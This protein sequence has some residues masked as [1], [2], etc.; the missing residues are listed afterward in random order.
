MRFL[1]L[2]R[3]IHM[4]NKNPSNIFLIT[5]LYAVVLL[6]D[7]PVRTRYIMVDQFGYRP[8]D[9]KVAV[10]AD[11]Q[12][13]RNAADSFVPGSFL[14]VRRSETD[15]I[16][17]S[18]IPA[19]WNNGQTHSQSGDRGW[20]FDFTAVETEGI[21]FIYDPANQV[22]SYPFEINETVYLDLLKTAFKMYFYNR[23]GMAK[24]E[25]FADPC[26]TDGPAFCG[27]HQ[28]TEA[29]YVEDKNNESLIR[30]MSGGWF[31]A[32]DYNKYVTNAE[33][34]LHQLLDAYSQN[35][36]VWT[37]DFNIPESYNGLPD[38]ID[39]IIWELDWIK[40]M[41]GMVDGGV[42]IKMGSLV[43]TSGSPPSTDKASRY[44]G[45][46]CS[47]STLTAASVFAHSALIFSEF[48]QLDDYVDDLIQRAILAWQWVGKHDI[49]ENCDSQEI[50][51]GDAD[52][53]RRD[54]AMMAVTAAV[55]LFAVTGDDLYND[56]VIDHYREVEAMEW[57]GPYRSA[58]GDALLYYASRMDGDQTVQ[59]DILDSKISQAKSDKLYRFYDNL[60]LYRAY[61]PDP[62]YH[63]GSNVVKLDVGNV[64]YDMIVYE[65]DPAGYDQYLEKA[66]SS[67]H[68]LHGVNP[69]SKV[70]LS[71]VYE[72]GADNCVNEIYHKWYVSKTKWDNALISECGPAP[73]YVIGG[74]NKKYS[75][76]EP[77]IKNQ[78]VQKAYKD[79]NDYSNAWEITEA[80]IYYQS[81]YL[82]LLSKFVGKISE[83]PPVNHPPVAVNDTLSVPQDAEI[84]IQVLANDSDADGDLLVIQSVDTA[85]IS[86]SVRIDEGD[87]AITYNSAP[88]YAGE[89]SLKY[90]ISDGQGGMDTASVHITVIA[91]NHPPVAMIDSLTVQQDS[92]VTVHVLENDSDPDGDPL[93]ILEA[94]DAGTSGSVAVDPGDTTLTFTP[95]PGFSGE[96][97]FEYVISD[98]QGGLDTAEVRITVEEGM[99]VGGIAPVPDVFALFQNHPNPFNPKTQILISLCR[100][101]PVIIE[102]TDILGKTVTTLA[103]Y[104]LLGAG[105]HTFSFDGSG[106]SAG[107]YFCRLQSGP[108]IQVKKLVLIK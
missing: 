106:L 53:S 5:I 24:E 1:I 36:D 57:W 61:M 58:S 67:L 2:I 49:R 12:K 38:L 102:I 35:P 92:V 64:N 96:T 82:K 81:A 76:S 85:G 107:I 62:Q 101:G 95:A 28:D 89:D 87:T 37:D 13:G 77:G 84:L 59:N 40:K 29:R 70:Y 45:P 99:G 65:L 41:Q 54:Q 105:I 8:M 18:G 72:I 47:S 46:K 48:S 44:Y 26:W 100:P 93:D 4:P 90:L 69:W 27:P 104:E 21:Y 30:D 97:V 33:E 20:W 94:G 7:P 31:D 23:C 6:A 42:H 74:P 79:D 16:V 51:S 55:Y 68:Y 52:I 80:G 32:G 63:W 86:G 73:G 10:I 50:K 91:M 22:G 34:V 3:E 43:Y 71:N 66:I 75:G 56:Y 60:D 88:D 83:P 78:P 11:P 9:V 39:E 17:F 25:P 14:E 108:Q 15:E 103:D 19:V 98:G